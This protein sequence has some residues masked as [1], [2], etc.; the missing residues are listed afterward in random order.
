M[1]WINREEWRRKIKLYVQK[2]LK[3]IDTLYINKIIIIIII[4]IIISEGIS[5]KRWHEQNF[6]Q[7]GTD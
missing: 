7:T 1:E 5:K 3:N 6:E 4:I 2:Y